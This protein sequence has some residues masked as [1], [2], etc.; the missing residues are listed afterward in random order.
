MPLGALPVPVSF[1]G[2]CL[3]RQGSM[4]ETYHQPER[5]KTVQWEAR[6]KVGGGK[7]KPPLTSLLNGH[8]GLRAR[9]PVELAAV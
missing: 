1:D 9:R 4:G 7:T 3:V 5:P 2:R 8:R 6:D